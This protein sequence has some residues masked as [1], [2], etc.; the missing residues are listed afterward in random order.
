M[1]NRVIHP[2]PLYYPED[3]KLQPV[4]CFIYCFNCCGI[5]SAYFILFQFL[6]AGLFKVLRIYARAQCSQLLCK[7]LCCWGFFLCLFTPSSCNALITFSPQEL[8]DTGLSVN[9]DFT[10]DRTDSIPTEIG[11]PPSALWVKVGNSKWRRRHRERKQ[12]PDAELAIAS[13]CANNNTKPCFHPSCSP[14]PEP[15]QK[16]KKENKEKTVELQ[17]EIYY[18]CLVREFCLPIVDMPQWSYRA[19]MHHY[20]PLLTRELKSAEWVQELKSGIDRQAD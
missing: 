11:R 2:S 19:R 9:L 12:K 17:S 16:K 3:T 5:V 6:R 20:F 4:K 7:F 13:D 10:L 1:Q 15:L 8:I 14:T 18:K